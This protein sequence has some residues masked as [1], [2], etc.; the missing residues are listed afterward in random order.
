MVDWDF[1]SHSCLH[2]TTTWLLWPTLC[3]VGSGIAFT[4]LTL[5]IDQQTFVP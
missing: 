1:K 2:V 3:R 4:C 5:V